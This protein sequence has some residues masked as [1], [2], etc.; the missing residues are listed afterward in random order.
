[1]KLPMAVAL[2]VAS[3]WASAQISIDIPGISV[4]TGP[5]SKT[6]SS[7]NTVANE[8]GVIDPDA[9]VEGVTI[10]NDEL[11]IDGVKIARGTKEYVSKKSRKTYLI[12]WGKKGEGV[13]V[14]EKTK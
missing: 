1:M 8:K 14:S 9:D 7:G 11:F 5:G 10:I 3:Q 4:K 12:R 13:T 2:L 6:S